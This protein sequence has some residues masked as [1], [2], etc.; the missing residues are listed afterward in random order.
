[1]LV[2][3]FYEACLSKNLRIVVCE[4][5]LE[6]MMGGVLSSKTGIVGIELGMLSCATG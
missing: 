2:F 4:T 1:M 6:T 3:F 5:L